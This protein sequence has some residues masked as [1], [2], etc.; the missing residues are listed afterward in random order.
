MGA[1]YTR[2]QAEASKRYIAD[3][4]EIRFRVP[5]GKKEEYKQQAAAAGK[6]LNQYIIDRMD[7]GEHIEIDYQ[8]GDML[9][10]MNAR[11][12]KEDMIV[13]KGQE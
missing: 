4:D 8:E 5:K 2:S 6:S 3:L 9:K 10:E 7:A 1:K 11:I 12:E 13:I